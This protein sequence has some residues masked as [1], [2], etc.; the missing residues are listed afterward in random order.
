M[1][2]DIRE[3]FLGGGLL[4]LY[5]M[6]EFSSVS[7]HFTD[8]NALVNLSKGKPAYV[9]C[10]DIDSWMGRPTL[11][12]CTVLDENIQGDGPGHWLT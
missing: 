7:A 12:S 11:E 3:D 8:T 4:N 1:A 5:A 10:R 2:K 9:R 6:D